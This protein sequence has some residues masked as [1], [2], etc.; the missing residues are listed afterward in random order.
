MPKTT[1]ILLAD[2]HAMILAALRMMI[3]RIE[4]VEVV[5]EAHNG[6][7]AVARARELRPDLVIMDISMSEL[8]GIEAAALIKAESPET[9]VLI[10]SSHASED[11]VRRAIRAGVDGYL[12]KGSP[13][14]ELAIAIR[15]AAEGNSY[16]SPS[17]SRLVMA[18]MARAGVASESQL[19]ALTGRQREILQ[20][21]AEGKSTKE[22]AF[23]LE[24]SVKTV[25]THRAA[26]MD[27]LDIHDVAGLVVFAVRNGLIDMDD[28]ARRR[29]GGA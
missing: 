5:A 24:V 20:M 23:G 2:D 8:N 28:D 29:S 10:L 21:I 16:L 7:D 26:I 4:G 27:R 11:Y 1:R 13:P 25:E 15:A 18:G 19:D 22:I 17:I 3:Q 6:R 14:E 12:L 9:R